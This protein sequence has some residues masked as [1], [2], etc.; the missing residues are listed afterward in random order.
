MSV[1]PNTQCSFKATEDVLWVRL[2]F[3]SQSRLNVL[4]AGWAAEANNR[5]SSHRGLGLLKVA[6]SQT[7]SVA[8]LSLR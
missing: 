4:V 2:A 5:G 3:D 8:Y 7:W 1:V 6:A